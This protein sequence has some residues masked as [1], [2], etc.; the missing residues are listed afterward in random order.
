[1]NSCTL[2]TI[3]FSYYRTHFPTPTTTA[4]NKHFVQLPQQRIQLSKASFIKH[5][6]TTGSYWKKCQ[7]REDMGNAGIKFHF[8]QKKKAGEMDKIKSH[9]KPTTLTNF[10]P[11]LISAINWR[12]P[13]PSPVPEIRL[14]GKDAPTRHEA[15]LRAVSHVGPDVT[16]G[17]NRLLQKSPCLAEGWLI[18][19]SFTS[20]ITRFWREKE[21][22]DIRLT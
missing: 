21:T 9:G 8:L 2:R 4:A 1:M 12:N 20:R 14:D 13:N 10:V 17:T 18:V 16:A 6:Y 7:G 5:L 15:V 19:R 11:L 3:L 22:E